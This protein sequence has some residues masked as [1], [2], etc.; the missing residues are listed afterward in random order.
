MSTLFC[1]TRAAVLA[2]VLAL[3][4]PVHAA[5]NDFF[6]NPARRE[7]ATSRTSTSVL[8]F[9]AFNAATKSPWPTFS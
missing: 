3:L 9:A 2:L 1:R 4:T 8:I 7:F 6:E 5:A